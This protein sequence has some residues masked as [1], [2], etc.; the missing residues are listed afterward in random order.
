MRKLS[1][2]LIVFTLW[3][4]HSD[5]TTTIFRSNASDLVK[6]GYVFDEN[7]QRIKYSLSQEMKERGYGEKDVETQWIVC[8]EDCSSQIRQLEQSYYDL[9]IGM[10]ENS[11]NVLMESENKN[12]IPFLLYK[13]F[14]PQIEMSY[15]DFLFHELLGEKHKVLMVQEDLMEGIDVNQDLLE[16]HVIEEEV[17]YPKDSVVIY[18]EKVEEDLNQKIMFSLVNENQEKISLMSF[19]LD[20]PAICDALAKQAVSILQA[21]EREE[22]KRIESKVVF[23]QEG[24]DYLQIE[25]LAEWQSLMETK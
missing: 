14:S 24:F 17:T 22:E 12:G 20:I 16:V 10:G 1:C 25:P 9:I 11:F 19:G 4:C 13:E 2:I 6:I 3:G 5:G 7:V 8:E 21:N 15:F 23:Y 18:I